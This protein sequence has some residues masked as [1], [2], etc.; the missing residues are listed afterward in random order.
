MKVVD[1]HPE[2]LLDKE[3]RGELSDVERERLDAHLARCV[4][5]RFE[6]EARADFAEDLAEHVP[7]QRLVALLES[8]SE[9][10]AETHDAPV[11]KGPTAD[12]P[13]NEEAPVLRRASV[14]PGRRR[15]H[16]TLLVAA[17]LCLGGLATAG[18]QAW[19]TAKSAPNDTEAEHALALAA[20]AS[21]KRVASAPAL[22]AS[23]EVMMPD[24][25]PEPAPIASEAPNTPPTPVVVPIVAPKVTAKALLDDAS[26]ARRHGE[27]SRALAS[28][29]RLQTE[30]PSSREAHAAEAIAGRLLLD[31]GDLEP[32]LRSFD[33]YRA[34]GPGDLD[35]AAMVGRATALDRLGRTAEAR[36]A[37]TALLD[38]FPTTPYA[39]HAR[40]RI[41]DGRH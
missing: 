22:R 19:V 6:R 40:V 38:A 9:E 26:D 39:E 25:L 34:H 18:V 41:G 21:N 4:T 29:R 35:E 36:D 30:F 17:A 5:C 32:A 15:L 31:R 20:S 16:V 1:L 37:W 33:A 8:V 3:I 12:A 2:D 11:A 7:S 10:P 14:R 27:D 23:A 28:L 13:G 24:R